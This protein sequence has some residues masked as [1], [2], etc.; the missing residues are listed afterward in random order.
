MR[1]PSAEQDD[2]RPLPQQLGNGNGH[3]LGLGSKKRPGTR[4]GSRP[5]DQPVW[6]RVS[7]SGTRIPLQSS[8]GA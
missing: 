4:D 1:F 5:H 2:A 7:S 8:I 3:G 6:A